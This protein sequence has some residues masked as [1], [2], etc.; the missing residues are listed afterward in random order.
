[1]TKRGALFS[2]LL[3]AALW[4][5][6]P[7]SKSP[8]TESPEQV[9]ARANVG[10]ARTWN[11]MKIG[12]WMEMRETSKREGKETVVIRRQALKSKDD[13]EL[14]FETST[15]K[16]EDGEKVGEPKVTETTMKA[17]GEGLC[18]DVKEMPPETLEVDGRKIEC[19]VIVSTIPPAPA[20]PKGEEGSV[21]Q[22]VWY[23]PTVKFAGGVV[24]SMQESEK[25]SPMVLTSTM[26]E[27]GIEIT[28]SG[29]KVSC[30]KLIVTIRGS[31]KG[32]IETFQSPE[33]PGGLVR[34]HSYNSW[35]VRDR[36]MEAE[37]S[38]ELLD[39]H[40]EPEDPVK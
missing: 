29:K 9:A 8:P 12:S 23:S 13:Q 26:K 16:V 30:A 4:A 34:V 25:P 1:M 36:K 20:A 19:R 28:V 21:K 10:L 5:E 3:T 27:T 6:D 32:E 22:T 38:K 39:F 33:V 31:S 18:H 17:S 11:T 37:S 24:K 35:M 14:K 7:S 2:L 40:V 15:W